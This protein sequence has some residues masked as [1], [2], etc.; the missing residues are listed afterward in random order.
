MIIT[1]I[2]RPNSA[3]ELNPSFKPSALAHLLLQNTNI[4]LFLKHEST[5]YS[6]FYVVFGR[7]DI[8]VGRFR[9]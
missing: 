9:K 8:R 1:C 3:S 6:V 5:R 4:H 7:D 2:A